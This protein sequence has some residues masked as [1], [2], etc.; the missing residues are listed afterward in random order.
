MKQK[1]GD[2]HRCNHCGKPVY[3]P[4]RVVCLDDCGHE[5]AWAVYQRESLGEK[6]FKALQKKHTEIG[7]PLFGSWMRDKHGF[8]WGAGKTMYD[9]IQ[10]IK[11]G[12]PMP[13]YVDIGGFRIWE[14]LDGSIRVGSAWNVIETDQVFEKAVILRKTPETA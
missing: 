1:Q 3:Y 13:K 7:W 5:T 14:L 10:R 12:V 8:D 11:D 6:V 9:Y 2:F 4:N